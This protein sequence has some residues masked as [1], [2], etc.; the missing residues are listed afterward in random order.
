MFAIAAALLGLIALLATLQYKWLGQISGAERE[1]MT[2]TLNQRANGFAQD[3]DREVTRA[4]LL[5]QLDP[6]HPEQGPAAGLLARYDRWQATARFP[7]MIKDV[8]LVPPNAP[9]HPA[10][11]QRLNVSTRFMPGV[12]SRPANAFC[13]ST[14]F[15]ASRF[16]NSSTA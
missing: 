12:A 11:I 16:I 5:F 9:D 3:V 14:P 10:Q 13:T 15:D 7:R 4:Y 6:M 8:Y 2:S 1:R